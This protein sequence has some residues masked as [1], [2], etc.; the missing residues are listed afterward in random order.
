[1]R[2]GFFRNDEEHQMQ[3]IR[4][5]RRWQP[6]IVIGNAPEDRHPDHGRAGKLIADACFL[7]GLRRIETDFEG[8]PQAA[9]R[10]KRVYH[11]IQ[12]RM[13]PP[14]FVV[15]I[16]D[17]M[18]RKLAAIQCYKS[19]FHNPESGSD[20]PQTYIS[21]ENFLDQIRYR[22]ALQGKQI[23]TRYGEGLISQNVTGIADLN[24]LLLPDTP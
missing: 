4:Y 21:S 22:D 18:D 7:A 24:S 10:P 9:W 3:L 14:T 15:D 23:G 5:I 16:S 20:E 2:D 13:L 19:Q 17:V 12:D 6:R 8:S 1:M 11:M